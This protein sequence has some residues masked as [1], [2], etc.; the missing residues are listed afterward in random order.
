MKKLNHSFLIATILS[1]AFATACANSEDGAGRGE[2]IGK[3]SAALT[4]GEGAAHDVASA[5]FVVVP[6]GGSCNDIPIAETTGLIETEALQGNL[7]PAETEV[8]RAFID[9]LMVLPPGDYMVCVTPLQSNG[10][11]SAECAPVTGEVSVS[12]EI[13]T[14]VVLISQCDGNPNGGLDVVVGLND[15]PLITDLNIGPSKFITTCETASLTVEASD[16]NGDSLSYDWEI[17]SGP[18][19]GLLVE[20]G[21]TAQFTPSAA[22]D[23]ELKV[24]VYDATG[25]ST[26]L[27]FPVHVSQAEGECDETPAAC[28]TGTY[29]AGDFC[30]VVA[31]DFQDG[32][33]SCGDHGLV[34]PYQE[35]EGVEWTPELMAEV[36][37]AIGCTNL[38][39]VSG[40]GA[41]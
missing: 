4:L 36:T 9:G 21:A 1:A 8:G 40:V 16:P 17:I 38:G 25:G 3:L 13:T 29:D 34:G 10:L 15:P 18:A 37:A 39:V 14:E 28:P 35:T 31:E 22:G 30:W 19:G 24:T 12:P 41:P 6:S 32:E 5:H 26:S 7:D 23:Y 20:S 2:G 11:P 33:Q 27:S